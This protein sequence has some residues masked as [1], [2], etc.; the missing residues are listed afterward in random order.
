MRRTPCDD[1]KFDLSRMFSKS[2]PK[3]VDVDLGTFLAGT[4]PGPLRPGTIALAAAGTASTSDASM[5]RRLV[6]WSEPMAMA[7]VAATR[8]CA[9]TAVPGAT[10][11]EHE[12]ESAR[13]SPTT[14]A[15]E[16]RFG[17]GFTL[18]AGGHGSISGPTIIIAQGKERFVYG[19]SG[20]LSHANDSIAPKKAKDGGL[21]RLEGRCVDEDLNEHQREDPSLPAREGGV[22]PARRAPGLASV[23]AGEDARP[24]RSGQSAVAEGSG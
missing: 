18:V 1:Q 11:A 8:L 22:T 19:T 14:Y 12:E 2:L 9:R 15:G 4:R 7:G 21:D 17:Q 23:P 16:A 10:K 6:T 3:P 13:A 5:A 24:A 20:C